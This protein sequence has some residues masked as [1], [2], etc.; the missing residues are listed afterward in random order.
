MT[1]K[2]L[3]SDRLGRKMKALRPSRVTSWFLIIV[4][5]VLNLVMCSEVSRCEINWSCQQQECL[6]PL[7]QPL[8]A[9]GKRSTE[10]QFTVDYDANTFLMDGRPFRFISGSIHYFRAVP[11]VWED[12]L[13]AM[14]AGGLNT[15]ST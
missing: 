6:T 5:A 10:R 15:I 3:H 4:I 11:E 9:N 14:K 13:L 7:K 8:Q 12:R 2:Q 1:D